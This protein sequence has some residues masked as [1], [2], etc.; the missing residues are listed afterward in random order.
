MI[1]EDAFEVVHKI[2]YSPKTYDC[3]K[4]ARC[5]CSWL[6]QY[7]K[8]KTQV[9][10]P[11]STRISLPKEGYKLILM[12]NGIPSSFFFFRMGMGL[13]FIRFIKSSSNLI[14]HFQ[15]VPKSI[16]VRHTCHLPRILGF[17]R[18]KPEPPDARD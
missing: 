15:T 2:T 14:G 3:F 10:V 16:I 6:C 13:R 4:I 5:N 17:L 8:G 12:E 7:M 1:C 18:N 11:C 9:V